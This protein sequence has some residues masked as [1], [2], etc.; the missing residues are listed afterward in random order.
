[1]PLV[2]DMAAGLV[3]KT[4]DF[5]LRNPWL[6]YQD[7]LDEYLEELNRK[8]DFRAV[9]IENIWLYKAK[10]RLRSGVL[11]IL[12]IHDIHHLRIREFACRDEQSP[13]RIDR[14]RESQIFNQFD[15]VIAIQEQEA[16]L[17]CEMCPDRT[18]LTVGCGA[19]PQSCSDHKEMI[20][21]G[22]ILYVG[23]YNK[24]NSDGLRYFLEHSWPKIYAACSEAHLRVC[25]NVYRSFINKSYERTEFLRVVEDIEREYWTAEIVINPIWIGTGLKIKTVEALSNGKPLITTPKGVEG[26][27]GKVSESCLVVVVMEDFAEAVVALLQNKALAHHY[28][29]KASEYA[30]QY[31]SVEAVYKDLLDYLDK[32]DRS[33]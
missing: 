12:D 10:N 9:I 21:P 2:E 3:G 20:V 13:L 1:M 27:R 5:P 26:M 17:I 16:K 31:L 32:I 25:G 7:G 22:R 14:E 29:W 33:L 15:A 8:Y 4:A 28:A 23:G 6:R 19:A 24:P 30:A 18:V 11:R